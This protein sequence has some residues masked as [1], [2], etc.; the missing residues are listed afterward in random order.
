MHDAEKAITKGPDDVR[1][2]LV[3]GR[4][5]LERGTAGSL[6]DLQKAADLSQRK[7]GTVL[8]WLAAALFQSGKKS[9]ALKVQREAA[10]CKPED[11]EI[12]DQL[13]EFEKAKGE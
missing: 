13:R 3:R 11:G 8:H 6:A 4:V 12:Q 5:R 7:D 1:A 10:K 9:E 2:Y